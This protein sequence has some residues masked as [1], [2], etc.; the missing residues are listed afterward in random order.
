MHVLNKGNFVIWVYQEQYFQKY[1]NAKTNISNLSII[2][3]YLLD[4]FSENKDKSKNFK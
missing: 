3:K 1:V 4:T 2:Y